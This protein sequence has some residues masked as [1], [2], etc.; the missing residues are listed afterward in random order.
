MYSSVVLP[1]SVLHRLN[2]LRSKGCSPRQGGFH[3]DQPIHGRL[4]RVRASEDA[5]AERRHRR[6]G[7]GRPANDTKALLKDIHVKWNKFSDQEV[8]ALK[9]NDDLVDQLVSR[10]VLAKDVAQRDADALRAGRNI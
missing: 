3:N 1:I 2:D 10:Y 5:G 9:S 7:A 4:E 6:A 8:G